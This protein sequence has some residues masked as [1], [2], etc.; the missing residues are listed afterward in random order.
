MAYRLK[1]GETVPQNVQRIA[2]EELDNA[3]NELRRRDRQKRDEAVHECRKSIKKTRALLRLMR[4]ELGRVFGTENKVLQ[5]VGRRLS[6]LRDIAAIIG[7]FDKIVKK[8]AK[9]GHAKTLASFRKELLA[10][11][12][13]AEHAM[14]IDTL[15]AS[16]AQPLEKMR[17]RVKKWPVSADGFAAIAPGLE[18]TYKDGRKALAVAHKQARPQ[19]FH[20]WRKRVK[21]HWYHVRLLEDLWTEVAT[22]YEGS[23]HDLET[24]LGEDHN[25]VVLL[26]KVTSEPKAFGDDKSVELFTQLVKE[27]QKELRD[28][29]RSLGDRIYEETP[30]RFV[31]RMKHL[32]EAWQAEP[33]TMKP[34]EKTKRAAHKA[35]A[36]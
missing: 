18:R 19:D 17:R 30:K 36:A 27:Y 11:K 33:K 15:L 23:L 2:Q 32:W 22:A 9:A 20:E 34:V 4:P 16:E 25:S 12:R 10:R 35:H 1:S 24:W 5:G 29:S 7:T 6:E 13:K 21:D 26:E 14:D 8:D 28:N 31:R 3:I